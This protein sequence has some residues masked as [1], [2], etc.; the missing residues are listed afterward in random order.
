M[1]DNPLFEQLRRESPLIS[2]AILTADLMCLGDQLK[3]LED[4]GVKLLH[5]DV[6]DGCFCPMTTVGP[7]FIKAVK[8]PLL[9][10]VHL[11]IDDPL[12]KLGD[13]ITAG[14]DLLTINIESCRHL[15][16]ALQII[17]QAQNVN[18]PDR[19][20]LR[21]VS[22]NPAT[23][24]EVIRPILDEIELVLLL[25]VNPGWGGQK[26]IDNVHQ[27]FIALQQMLRQAGK[28]ILVCI[29]GGVKKTNVGDIAAIGADI[30]VSGSAVFDG[31]NPFE[32]AKFMLEAMN[33]VRRHK[34]G[35]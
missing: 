3:L 9:K 22:L 27:K 24:I 17:A 14:A 30:I 10:D 1:P 35:N 25:A 31:K 21:G 5:F 7:P 19:G 15:H 2:V 16:R 23:P 26:F 12:P 32:N 6:M 13:Y 29:D 11:M 28:D 4:A 8:T 33:E 34:A 20:I 18:K